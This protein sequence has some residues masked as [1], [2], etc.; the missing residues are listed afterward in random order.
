M[1]TPPEKLQF[2]VLSMAL[3]ICIFG[4]SIVD[5]EAQLELRVIN[6]QNASH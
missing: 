1:E 5:S 3:G 2:T 4:K 6:I